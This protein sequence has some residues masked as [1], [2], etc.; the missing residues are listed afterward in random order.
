M[1]QSETFKNEVIVLF[2]GYS[3]VKDKDT[4]L[5]NCTSTLVK[6]KNSCIIV[7]TRTAWDGDELTNGMDRIHS[8]AFSICNAFE[9]NLHIYIHF[10]SHRIDETVNKSR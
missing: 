8:S 1:S 7:D 2:D 10:S 4:S 6:G 5:A 9:L 3:E